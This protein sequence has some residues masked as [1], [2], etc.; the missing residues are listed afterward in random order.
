MDDLEKIITRVAA[1]ELIVDKQEANIEKT[2][3]LTTN[4]HT[5]LTGKDPLN[6]KADEKGVIQMVREMWARDQQAEEW[7][8]R[9]MDVEDVVKK[10]VERNR[11]ED[12]LKKENKK[13]K[14][15]W[16]T[17]SYRAL[18]MTILGLLVFY[19]QQLIKTI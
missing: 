6:P 13:D 15:D 8:K 4:I 16:S 12:E 17:W 3:E 9:F 19:V 10:I 14:K 1:L 11:I 18:L 5:A 2:M 7:I